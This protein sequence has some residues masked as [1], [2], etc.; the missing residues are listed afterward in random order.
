MNS[1]IRLNI[2]AKSTPAPIIGGIIRIIIIIEVVV[3][4]V[5]FKLIAVCVHTIVFIDIIH[6]SRS[7]GRSDVVFFGYHAGEST[8]SHVCDVVPHVID[9]DLMIRGAEAA[10]L[11]VDGRTLF[12]VHRD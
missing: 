1:C 6:F 7:S 9:E 11:E 5:V 2:P 12:E 8:P 4:V 3:I 10:E